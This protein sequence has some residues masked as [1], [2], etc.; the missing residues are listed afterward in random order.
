MTI[1]KRM[2]Y[3]LLLGMIASVAS[4]RDGE[5]IR[6]ATEGAFPPWNAMDTSGKPVGFDI[7]VGSALCERAKLKCEFLTQAW[8]GIIPGLNEIGRASCRERG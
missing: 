2:A 6:I 3:V 8:D 1:L 7:D 4:A 5:T